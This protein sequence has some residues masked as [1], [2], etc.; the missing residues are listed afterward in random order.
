MSP[1]CPF[2][3]PSTLIKNGTRIIIHKIEFPRTFRL[4]R[5][6]FTILTLFTNRFPK[7]SRN[8]QI[9]K[10]QAQTTVLIKVGTIYSD[11]LR[12][13][14]KQEVK[15]LLK[16]RLM[17]SRPLWWSTEF[18]RPSILKLLGLLNTATLTGTST[19]SSIRFWGTTHSWL[20]STH[21]CWPPGCFWCA[22]SRT[23]WSTCTTTCC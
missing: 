23:N 8:I 12:G 21:Y 3:N 5:R 4:C 19:R 16:A 10:T 11:L 2:I 14:S 20:W 15:T 7:W 13:V 22:S 6:V 1:K 18:L 17:Q 9:Q